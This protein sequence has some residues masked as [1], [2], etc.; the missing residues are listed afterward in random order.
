M[1]A[2]GSTI[3]ICSHISQIPISQSPEHGYL[4]DCHQRFT[5][6]LDHLVAY[7]HP[8]ISDVSIEFTSF[9]GQ[10]DYH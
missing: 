1:S 3:Q 6:K 2:S 8:S 4:R 7:N 5:G 10:R 9:V